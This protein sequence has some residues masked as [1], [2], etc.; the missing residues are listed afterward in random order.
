MLNGRCS[1]P[2]SRTDE[3]GTR[4][5]Q[6]RSLL[7][8]LSLQLGNPPEPFRIRRSARCDN[9]RDVACESLQ[10]IRI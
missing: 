6:H 10:V 5:S 8:H 7:P 1:I 9:R 3:P 2:T 4:I